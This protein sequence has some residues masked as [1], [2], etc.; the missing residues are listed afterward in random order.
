M[1]LISTDSLSKRVAETVLSTSN[2]PEPKPW[3]DCCSETEGSIDTVHPFRALVM[4]EL[5][6]LGFSF[7]SCDIH[8]SILLANPLEGSRL[9]RDAD[10]EVQSRGYK[11]ASVR[12]LLEIRETVLFS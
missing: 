1:L 5:N 6:L 3:L 7:L 11:L 12:Q 4:L 9:H 8:R 10:I 2:L